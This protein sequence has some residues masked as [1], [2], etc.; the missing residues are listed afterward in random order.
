MALGK[1]LAKRKQDSKVAA[2][3][4]VAVDDE[5][6]RGSASQP[7][8][9]E[10]ASQ[11]LESKKLV[12][13]VF[14]AGTEEIAVSVGTIKEV[15]KIPKVTPVP[16]A[17]DYIKGVANVR[18]NVVAVLDIGQKMGLSE[19]QG[20]GYLLVINSDEVG[21][22]LLVSKVPDTIE[23]TEDQLDEPTDIILQIQEEEYI[24]GIIK[25]DHRMIVFIDVVAMIGNEKWEN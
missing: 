3:V 5:V 19:E 17:P 18:G 10:V 6:I 23:T 24:K 25:R 4:A 22:G 15:I 20:D 9:P 1:N 16:Q 12:L 21:L 11:V 7:L 8:E 13:I 2:D 14:Q